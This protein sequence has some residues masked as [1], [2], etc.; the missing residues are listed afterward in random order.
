MSLADLLHHRRAVRDYDPNQPI[1]ADKVA[2]CLRL[3]VL[4]P[5]SSNMQLYQMYHITDK[6][7]L[8]RLGRACLSQRA[9]TTADQMVVFVTR[10]DLHL[11]HA[12]SVLAFEEQNIPSYTP[13]DKVAKRLTQAKDYYQRLMPALY[14]KHIPMVGVARK[15]LAKAIQL[16]RPMQTDLSVQDMRVV[17]HKSCALAAQTF[18][19]AMA[20]IGYDTCPMEG[21][22]AQQIKAILSLPSDAEIN[23]VVSCGIRSDKGVWGARFRLPFHEFYRRV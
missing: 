13:A 15:G 17:V 14:A 18:M 6:G 12:K 16:T 5:S 8:M 22:D 21:F 19:L 4:A 23:M 9:A 10:Q 2:D 1:D 7:V 20:E 3:A 11:A